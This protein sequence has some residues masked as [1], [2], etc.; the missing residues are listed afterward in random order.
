MLKFLSLKTNVI[1]AAN[2]GNDNNN[3]IAVINTDHT[4]NGI[5]IKDI[6]GALIFNIVAIKFIAPNNELIPARCNANIAKSTETP[7]CAVD[8]DKL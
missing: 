1:H 8:P 3:N 7:E 2:I 5:C 4:N 6:P